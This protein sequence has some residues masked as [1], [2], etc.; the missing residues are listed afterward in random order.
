MP[1]PPPPA[2]PAP[3][4][5]ALRRSHQSVLLTLAVC[6]AVIA[7][8]GEAPDAGETAPGADG[9]TY[10][11]TALAVVSILARRRQPARADGVRAHVALSL[12]SLVAAG[13]VGLVGVVASTAGTPRNAALVYVLAGALFAL[14]PPLGLARE[15]RADAS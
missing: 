3:L 7:L 15:T 12:L 4:Q 6:A 14:R 1:A 10:A 5:R 11:A 2:S 9:F 13:G 8:G